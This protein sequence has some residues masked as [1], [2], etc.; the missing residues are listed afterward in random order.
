MKSEK[1][2]LNF[3]KKIIK[4]EL[5]KILKREN[6]NEIAEE[7]FKFLETRTALDLNGLG[8]IFEH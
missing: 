7:C 3:G 6:K 5:E 1:Q 8:D 4:E 2:I